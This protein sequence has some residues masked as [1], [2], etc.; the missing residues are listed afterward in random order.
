M[1]KELYKQAIETFGVEAQIWM[2][3]EEMSE[4]IQAICKKRRGKTHN[5]EEEIVDCIIVLEQ[6]KMKQILPEYEDYISDEKLFIRMLS[7]DIENYIFILGNEA[8]GLL[9][10]KNTLDNIKE[11]SVQF[12]QEKLNQY[13][14]IKEARLKELIERS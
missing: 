13:M 14:Q 1:N 8:F 4:L 2:A 9:T 6:L 12:D 5:I 7:K 10:V 11:Y 3:I